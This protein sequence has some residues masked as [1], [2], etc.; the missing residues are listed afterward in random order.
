[1]TV[2]TQT[3]LMQIIDSLSWILVNQLYVAVA[4]LL[5]DWSILILTRYG[6]LRSIVRQKHALKLQYEHAKYIQARI[7]M[8]E[9]NDPPFQY[10]HFTIYV[11]CLCNIN[12]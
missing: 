12:V 9:C 10:I 4:L 8:M 5:L 2:R 1:M 7:S 11:Q 3:N 6:Q